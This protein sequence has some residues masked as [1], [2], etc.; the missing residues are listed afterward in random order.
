MPLPQHCVDCDRVAVVLNDT[1]PY[2]PECYR[3]EK[4][5]LLVDVAKSS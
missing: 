4:E 2:C 1:V 3:K 5:A